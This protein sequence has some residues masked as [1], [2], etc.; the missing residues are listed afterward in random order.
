MDVMH[1]LYLGGIGGYAHPFA[2][3]GRLQDIAF[4]Q[5]IAGMNVAA[6]SY[7]CRIFRIGTEKHFPYVGSVEHRHIDYLQDL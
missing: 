5:M 2:F 6:G 4:A 1:S 7:A 3:V